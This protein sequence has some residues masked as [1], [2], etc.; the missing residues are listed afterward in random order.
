MKE[1]QIQYY[2]SRKQ[3]K[4]SMTAH[5]YML[6]RNY[7]T[8]KIQNLIIIHMVR[9]HEVDNLTNWEI[10]RKENNV[11]RSIVNMWLKDWGILLAE[12]SGTTRTMWSNQGFQKPCGPSLMS[13]RC[14]IA[15]AT[16]LPLDGHSPTNGQSQ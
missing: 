4:L 2:L 12:R 15:A 11:R 9:S 16:F 5:S 10:A 13:P 14:L 3:T 8:W 6:W 7:K 1:E